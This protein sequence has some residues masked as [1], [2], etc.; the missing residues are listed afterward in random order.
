MSLILCETSKN[1]MYI[2]F[3]MKWWL[4]SHKNFDNHKSLYM[5]SDINEIQDAF[6][7]IMSYATSEELNRAEWEI[8]IYLA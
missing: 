3:Q 4:E 7:I 2:T 5:R 1:Y 8:W 6:F